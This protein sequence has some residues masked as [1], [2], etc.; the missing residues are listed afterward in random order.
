MRPT[1]LALAAPLLLGW[2]PTAALAQS[3]SPPAASSAGVKLQSSPTRIDALELSFFLPEGSEAQTVTIGA[4]PTVGVELP[5]S[6]GEMVIE[7]RRSTKT[8]LTVA[9]VLDSMIEQFESLGSFVRE[10]PNGKVFVKPQLEIRTAVQLSGLS[11]ERVYM[12]FPAT[13]VRP[14]EL[15]G[16]TVFQTEPGRFIVFDLVAPVAVAAESRRMYE[17]V[18]GTMD[19]TDRDALAAR[20]GAALN[21]TKA[22]LASLTPE[23]LRVLA[24]SQ[25]ER[26]E[27]MFTPARSGDDMDASEHG[28]RRIRVR[29]GFRGEVSGKSERSW[30]TQEKLPGLIVQLDAMA[31][32]TELRI[33]T[34][35]VYFVSEDLTE[36]AWTVRMALRQGDTTTE[37]SVNGARSG[38]G[39]I[40]KLE[41]QNMAPTVTRPLIQGE[42]YLPQAI[43]H[44][45]SPLLARRAQVGEFASYAY[46]PG[47][48]TITMRWDTVEQPADK[49]GLWIVR[50]RPDDNTPATSHVFNAQGRLM[51]SEL[52]NGRLW[53]PI[54]PDRLLSLWKRKGLPLE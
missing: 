6:L 27:R 40:V 41:Q 30:N 24:E 29:K 26:W 49:P 42:G 20:R 47:S 39:M 2:T 25:P 23:E 17:T 35:A 1:L 33:D 12:R 11:G 4:N 16:V 18:V 36:E 52:H 3:A 15:R 34:R 37:S 9:E 5:R 45:L 43:T 38:T 44:L 28:Y 31:I 32:E 50:S 54:E 22:V 7:G 13:D 48:N 10:T 19:V 46:N 14:E 53:E 8:D 51:R 21:R